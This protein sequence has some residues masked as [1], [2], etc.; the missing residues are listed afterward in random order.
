LSN[1]NTTYTNE[2]AKIEEELIVGTTALANFQGHFT[3]SQ[4]V[5]FLHRKIG[6]ITTPGPS[7]CPLPSPTD[8]TACATGV[9]SL[10]PSK[11]QETWDM[12]QQLVRF[13]EGLEEFDTAIIYQV[14]PPAPHWVKQERNNP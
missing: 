1:A 12:R 13:Y 10:L 8:R 9:S 2:I 14:C 3:I 5:S 4:M 11:A 7:H 6:G